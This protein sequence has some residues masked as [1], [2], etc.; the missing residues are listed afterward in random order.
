MAKKSSRI[1]VCDRCGRKGEKFYSGAFQCGG[2]H[3]TSVEV[4]SGVGGSIGG[5]YRD[6][7]F[8][9]DCAVEFERWMGQSPAP[10]R[11]IEEELLSN[12]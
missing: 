7:D 4:W 2:M 5:G 9:S 3:A 1:H 8:C 11:S 6:I 12:D 10:K